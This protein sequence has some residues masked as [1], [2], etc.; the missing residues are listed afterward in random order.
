V[1]QRHLPGDGA[2][3]PKLLRC[4]VAILLSL[5]KVARLIV[6]PPNLHHPPSL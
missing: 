6:S 3:L 4:Q 1:L 5:D 2:P